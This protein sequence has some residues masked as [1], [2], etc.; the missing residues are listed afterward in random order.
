MLLIFFV[1]AVVVLLSFLGEE[2][3]QWLLLLSSMWSP[4]MM[5]RDE[6]RHPFFCCFF[7]LDDRESFCSSF[8]AKRRR[9]RKSMKLCSESVVPCKDPNRSS[10]RYWMSCLLI[11]LKPLTWPLCMNMNCPYWKG[12]QLASLICSPNW[13][14][15][16]RS[17]RLI[18]ICTGVQTRRCSAYVSEDERRLNFFRNA[19]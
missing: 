7:L 15:K 1:V 6:S 17:H 5:L 16:L 9:C 4:G 8:F 2:D 11:F 18:E 10:W 12:W 13:L 3:R 19:S 14:V